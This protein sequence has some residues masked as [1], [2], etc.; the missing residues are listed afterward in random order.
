M[1]LKGKLTE[2]TRDTAELSI[3]LKLAINK[4]RLATIL[5]VNT[6]LQ[7]LVNLPSSQA[8][9]KPFIGS[10]PFRVLPKA[11]MAML[12]LA[13]GTPAVPQETLPQILNTAT[14]SKSEKI[15]SL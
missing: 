7:Q 14:I 13:Q 15:L 5:W 9:S 3:T 10:N 1:E 12:M 2:V 8:V 4:L 11:A 6:C